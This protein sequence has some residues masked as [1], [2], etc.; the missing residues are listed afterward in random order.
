MNN[1]T[2]TNVSLCAIVR[3]EKMNPAGGIVDF[4]DTIVPH[5]A[6]AVIV[7]TGSIDGTR[8]ILE[9]AKEKHL[10]LKV[11]DHVWKGYADARNRSL[12]AATQPYAFILDADERIERKS[13]DAI[14]EALD[15]FEQDYFDITSTHISP[16]GRTTT[17]GCEV[18]T[19]TLR[20][21]KAAP[22]FRFLATG[23]GGAYEYISM[24]QYG[25]VRVHN[26]IANA[27]ILHFLPD[28]EGLALKTTGWY[29]SM[30]ILCVAPSEV[31]SF[32]KWKAFNPQRS[33]Y[34]F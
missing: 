8:E 30:D 23:N 28:H 22:R 13:I 24:I 15:N 1:P 12:D 21:L 10:N 5:V 27:T 2:L 4:L 33:K 29:Y 14:K 20:I 11:V 16:D 34:D 18:P 6:E 7:D 17:N 3:D 25:R 31:P 32:P 26:P 9:A 19:M